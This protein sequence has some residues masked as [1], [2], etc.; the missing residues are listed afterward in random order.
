MTYF[1]N[2]DIRDNAGDPGVILKDKFEDDDSFEIRPS[3]YA[4]NAKLG[5]EY[6][7]SGSIFRVW[8]PNQENLFLNLYPSADSYSYRE[9]RMNKV[10][11][12]FELEIQGDL[13]GKY[14]CYSCG[15]REVTDPYSIASSINSARSFIA[16]MS[17]TD[18]PAFRE[19]TYVRTPAE[20]S[21]IYEL[22]VGDFTFSA[23]SG[24]EERGKYLGLVEEGTKIGDL[25]TGI[26]HLKDLGVTHVHLLPIYDFISVDEDPDRFGDKT[27][28]N[29]GYDPELYNVPE[30]VYSRNPE[31]PYSRIWEVKEMI[32]TFHK[33]GIGVILDVVYNH[34]YKTYDSNFNI[35]VPAYYYRSE[36]GIFSNGSGVGNE[37]AS[38]RAMARKFLIE[39]LLYWQSE[40]MVDGFRFDLMALIDRET[41]ELALKKLRQVNPYTIIYG[42]PWAGSRSALPQEKQTLWSYP[43]K[44]D[45]ALFNEKYRDSLRG[46]NDGKGRGF[47]QGDITEKETLIEGIKGSVTD[48][49]DRPR[50]TSESINYFSAHDNLILE[51]KLTK[52]NGNKERNGAMSKLAF[53]ILLTS[54]GIPFIH[55]GTEFRR[56]KYMLSNSYNASYDI[57]AIDWKLKQKYRDFYYYVRDLMNLRKEYEVFSLL[58]REEVEGRVR[59]IN[60]KNP[61][62][63]SMLYKVEKDR[64][65]SWLLVLHY[66]GWNGAKVS[67]EPLF[68]EFD[69]F[70]F[71][72]QKIFDYN[73]KTI[74][75][76]TECLMSDN[77]YIHLHPIST[78][79]YTIKIGE[80][81]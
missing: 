81:F 43:G 29:W 13:A 9:F 18:P 3:E 67:L 27:N 7:K 77:D 42:E 76:S 35:L 72:M 75:N 62:L 49:I 12:L 70:K 37:F 71:T 51:D 23:S 61:N 46:D 30:G 39:S 68:K 2:L 25:S 6:T 15:G 44:G 33:N 1:K 5:L 63:I 26:D 17:R 11:D 21:V 57:N 31:N 28:Y 14:Y 4:M 10:E 48:S 59:S 60:M 74:T 53:G 54:E 40:Y 20:K 45:F 8:A 16:D 78:T 38:E 22:H 19:L 47:I 36:N 80:K 52:S 69:C 41:I 50:K 73:G 24:V 66:N 56:T 79:I 55:E 64:D 58:E 32:K 34:T 65:D